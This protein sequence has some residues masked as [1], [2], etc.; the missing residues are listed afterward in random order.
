MICKK[1]GQKVR[2]NEKER[3]KKKEKYLYSKQENV[4]AVW[5]QS[6]FRQGKYLMKTPFP[7]H[8]IL[9]NNLKPVISSKSNR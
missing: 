6:N 7:L 3:R 8:M 1:G 5:K 4:K 9:K 2:K